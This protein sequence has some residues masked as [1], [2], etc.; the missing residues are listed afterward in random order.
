MDGS[1]DGSD[2]GLDLCPPES[3]PIRHP[4]KIRV[5]S[6]FRP[7]IRVEWIR[8]PSERGPTQVTRETF[9]DTFTLQDS[10]FWPTLTWFP[11]EADE[12]CG[13]DVV[14]ESEDVE[15]D[16]YCDMVVKDSEEDDDEDRDEDEH[17]MK[18]TYWAFIKV[19]TNQ[20]T[21]S[22]CVGPP[23]VRS[24]RVHTGYGEISHPNGNHPDATN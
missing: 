3:D 12:E 5:L 16:K 9:S 11:H 22:H 23:D 4:I 17:M 18:P 15:A 19:L 1:G 7:Y 8:Y 6:D 2:G 10:S 21:V 13:G 24:F 20:R 14:K